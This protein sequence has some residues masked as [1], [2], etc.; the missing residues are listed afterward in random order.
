MDDA[1]LVVAW[2]D[3][4]NSNDDI[5][6][7]KV[8]LDGTLGDSSLTPTQTPTP[9]STP[10]PTLVKHFELPISYTG[11]INSTVQQFKSA[12]WSTLTAAFDHELEKG[13]YRPF[14]GSTYSP[15]DCPKGV[16][17]ILC[18]DSHNGTDFSAVSGSDVLSVAAG[19]VLYVSDFNEDTQ[20]CVEEKSYGCVA[21]VEYEHPTDSNSTL[22]GLYAH[23]S[24][25]DV[26]I[27]ST[28]T[29]NTKIGIMGKTGCKGCGVH[30]HFSVLKEMPS[31]LNIISPSLSK[32]MSKNDWKTLLA[33]LPDEDAVQEK[34]LQDKDQA[35]SSGKAY[36]TYN[37]PNGTKFS[38]IDPS[39][40][41]SEETDPWSLPVDFKKKQSGCGLIS[42]YLW[43]HE[44]GTS[45]LN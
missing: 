43:R 30:L 18:Y 39:G 40:W 16:L 35:I 15:K 8:N 20:L 13:I 3:T 22:V 42:P 19:E 26:E 10:T 32:R 37:A 31:L 34:K 4:R 33:E 44:I 23:L 25:I 2:T 17:G 45:L 1:S 7:Q 28:V 36:C 29:Q 27:G 9:T 14:T 24:K 5:Y 11:R 6:A 12:F 38:F 41:K 21:L